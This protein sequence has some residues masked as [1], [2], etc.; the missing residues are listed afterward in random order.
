MSEE[1]QKKFV[2]KGNWILKKSGLDNVHQI[3][4]RA[5]ISAQTGY[6]YI[7][8]PEKV[9]A[10]DMKVLAT[11]LID[12]AGLTPKEVLEMKIGDLFDLVDA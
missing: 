12:G 5:R 6:K 8:T 11:L 1:K 10:F 7:Q 9:K 4:L 3:T 2:L